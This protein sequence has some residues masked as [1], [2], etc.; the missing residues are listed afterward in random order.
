MEEKGCRKR[1]EKAYPVRQSV[2]KKSGGGKCSVD[3]VP[4]LDLQKQ[5]PEINEKEKTTGNRE[6]D[7]S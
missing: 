7:C 5:N 3:K 1:H 6:E 2:D 4:F